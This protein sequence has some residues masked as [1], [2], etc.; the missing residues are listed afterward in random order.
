[1]LQIPRSRSGDSSRNFLGNETSQLQIRS[2]RSKKDDLLLFNF[3]AGCC[4]VLIGLVSAV[5]A[6]F[7]LILFSYSIYF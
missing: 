6:N 4:A 1:M 2:A 7:S 3:L 5:I